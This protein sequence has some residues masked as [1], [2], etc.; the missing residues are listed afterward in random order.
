MYFSYIVHYVE[1]LIF[2]SPFL[3]NLSKLRLLHP[4]SRAHPFQSIAPSSCQ[5]CVCINTLTV[6]R[7]YQSRGEAWKQSRP[8]REI[9]IKPTPRHDLHHLTNIN[10][11]PRK[12]A[13]NTVIVRR[14]RLDWCQKLGLEETNSAGRR[15]DRGCIRR[16][17][18]VIAGSTRSGTQRRK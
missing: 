14:M 17:L 9:I 5:T 10:A 13:G 2:R 8:V 18:V 6:K 3:H 12:D 15:Q 4:G 7:K 1:N 16:T 11:G